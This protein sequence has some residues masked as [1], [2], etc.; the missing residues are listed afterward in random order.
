V[1]IV[2][3]TIRVPANHPKSLATEP[4]PPISRNHIIP[5]RIIKPTNMLSISFLRYLIGF[6]KDV[7]LTGIVLSIDPC[8]DIV[9]RIGGHSTF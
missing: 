6:E 4:I 2:P 7:W 3:T 5:L 8:D 9:P 1:V